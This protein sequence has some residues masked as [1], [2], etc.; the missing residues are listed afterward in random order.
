MCSEIWRDT[1]HR[2]RS[3]PGC[4]AVFVTGFTFLGSGK[5]HEEKHDSRAR[6]RVTRIIRQ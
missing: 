4:L 3:M 2:L 1:D 5:Q 6:R